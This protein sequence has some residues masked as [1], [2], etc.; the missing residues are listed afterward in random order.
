MKTNKTIKHPI[1]ILCGI[2]F[3]FLIVISI[4]D[5][6]GV[7]SIVYNGLAFQIHC[8]SYGLTFWVASI[9]FSYALYKLRLIKRNFNII[10]VG[11]ILG[12]IWWLLTLWFLMAGFHG[13]IGGWY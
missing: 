7:K 1:I 2:G 9:I 11:L 10:F 4:I 3:I 13:V 12:G 8:Y 6:I 5:Y